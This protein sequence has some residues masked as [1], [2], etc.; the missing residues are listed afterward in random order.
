[1]SS[2]CRIAGWQGLAALAGKATEAEKL[3]L[4]AHLATCARCAEE[5]ALLA[6][7]RRLRDPQWQG[8]GQGKR[9]GQG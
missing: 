2:A 8:Q 1:M 4:E 3:E 5:H 7:M 6:P 9:Q